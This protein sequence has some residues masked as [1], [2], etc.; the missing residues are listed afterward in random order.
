MVDSLFGM[1]FS[2]TSNTVDSA[3]NFMGFG[4]TAA[5]ATEA[6]VAQRITRNC[7]LTKLQCGVNSNAK[8]TAVILHFRV[9][10]VQTGN[11][12]S[13]TALTTG[14]FESTEEQTPVA[15][16]SL[17]NVQLDTSP[18]GAAQALQLVSGSA[19]MVS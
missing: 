9:G 3:N 12:V 15:R 19:I 11:T 7:F 2:M 1:E 14:F 13:I 5:I 16:N 6:F 10:G 4:S 17:V 8:D 18:A